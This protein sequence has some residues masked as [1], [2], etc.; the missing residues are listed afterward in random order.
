MM[1]V[2]GYEGVEDRYF[3]RE[4]VCFVFVEGA[5]LLRWKMGNGGEACRFPNTLV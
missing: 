3:G 4:G 5:M 1:G 2:L